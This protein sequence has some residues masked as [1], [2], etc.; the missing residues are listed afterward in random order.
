MPTF[1]IFVCKLK[2][3]SN[4]ENVK[5]VVKTESTKISYR[6]FKRQNHL[7]IERKLHYKDK[8]HV[9]FDMY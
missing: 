4:R 1:S 2:Y 6:E 3:F 7:S 9:L 5:E 8:D